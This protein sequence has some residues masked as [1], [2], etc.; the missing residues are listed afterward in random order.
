M[1]E[2]ISL[3]DEI[4]AGGYQASLI[5]TYNAYL[6][7]YEEVVRPHL[8]ASG[9]RHN[10]IMMDAH[11]CNEA[12]NDLGSRPRSAG[13]LYSLIPVKVG[14]AFHPKILLLLGRNKGSLFVGS[15]NLTIAG[16]SSNLEL[17]NKFTYGS[18][19]D[20]KQIQA[21][22]AAL[23]NAYQ[24]LKSYM[25]GQPE[26]V[27]E[28]FEAFERLAPW[29]REPHIVD[30][31]TP[32]IGSSISGET[33]W[34]K[35]QWKL[36][37]AA[38]RI[39]VIGPFFD[40]KLQFIQRLAERLNPRRL[41]VGISPEEVEI[42]D[43]A[44]RLLPNARFVDA[45]LLGEGA[46]YLHAKAILI[47]STDG[48]EVL[49]TGSANPS[50]AAW[51][52]PPATRN[53][54]AVVIRTNVQ[55][56]VVDDIKQLAEQPDLTEA[57]WQYIR[58]RPKRTAE[59]KFTAPTL[60][61]AMAADNS[62]VINLPPDNPEL[63][64]EV[65]IFDG[66]GKLLGT[67]NNIA[68][69][70][71][72]LQISLADIAWYKAA[73]WVEL[74][75]QGIVKFRALIHHREELTGLGQTS[76]ERALRDS[77]ATLTGETPMLEEVLKIISKVIFA[78]D[79]GFSSNRAESSGQRTDAES[80]STS[81]IPQFEISIG[82]TQKGIRKKQFYAEGDLGLIL[83]AL[84]YGLGK[85]L[86]PEVQERHI[87]Q[88]SEEELV[89]SE[90]E[91]FLLI[92]RIDGTE[93]VQHC[94]KKIKKIFSRMLKQYEKAKSEKKPVRTIIQLAAVLGLI[95]HLRC[96]VEK[97]A[98][99]PRGQSLLPSIPEL[100][101]FFLESCRYLYAPNEALLPNAL[102]DLEGEDCPEL[103]YIRG[104]LV[105]LAWEC[106]F[107]ARLAKFSE[108]RNEKLDEVRA[109]DRLLQ[110]IPDMKSDA[111]AM[112]AAYQLQNVGCR[113]AGYDD[114]L[115]G[116][117]K[118][119]EK[120]AAAAQPRLHAVPEAEE[121]NVGDIVYRKSETPYFTTVLEINNRKV[122]LAENEGIWYSVSFLRMVQPIS[123]T[124][125][126]PQKKGWT[127]NDWR[128][129]LGGSR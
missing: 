87:S 101:K 81:E 13:K 30:V 82:A 40:A 75:V 5:A 34:E 60:V 11:R 68:C 57:S 33:L 59:E 112:A 20:R 103:A 89:G 97:A 32:F 74:S 91:E 47:E 9:C 22:I 106:D 50:S 124:A 26:I 8:T 110:L 121:L 54:E 7:F 25:E 41:I 19:R 69:N 93:L 16:Y 86:Y 45:Q 64:D 111:S 122:K 78:E 66:L 38:Q 104:Y 100:R 44:P 1:T 76:T 96:E 70:E 113:S 105:W 18:A 6:P 4:K 62:L 56:Q 3:L 84:I 35:V 109:V 55:G 21:E 118:W 28:M 123:A 95:C 72:C 39:F 114:W 31:D 61:L 107:D 46:G 10:L 116:H 51:L 67:L 92:H 36:P 90:E 77:L 48:Q 88:R 53:A 129:V 80:E 24:F 117:I 83:N 119:H 71:G 12:F 65:S 37:T 17:T 79:D 127:T 125:S 128:R 94:Q 120:I 14:G 126:P 98:W 49:I 115:A 52:A 102:V 58:N 85:G 15:H 29:L 63:W 2:R 73:S 23:Q 99:V 108:V 27:Q 42:T 43:D